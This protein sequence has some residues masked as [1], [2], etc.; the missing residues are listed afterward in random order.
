[1]ERENKDSFLKKEGI[2]LH[3]YACNYKAI[4]KAI[5]D[6]PLINVSV[7]GDTIVKEKEIKY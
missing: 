3:F 6:F 5:K 4:V 2:K 7:V 1:M